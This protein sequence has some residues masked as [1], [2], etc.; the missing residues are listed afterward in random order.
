VRSL[1]GDLTFS[2]LEIEMLE[3]TV[4]QVHKPA[5]T[6]ER[7][8]ET[9]LS[10]N[11]RFNGC[12][13]LDA[14]QF[15]TDNTYFFKLKAFDN[16][17]GK[18]QDGNYYNLDFSFLQ[19]IST[20]D[21]HIRQAVLQLTSDVEHA[22]KIRFNALLM[23][24]TKEDG[25]SIVQDF[26]RHQKQF[27]RDQF[28]K[29]YSLNL[30]AS[31]YTEGIINKYAENPPAWLLWEVCSFNTTNA[32]YKFFLKKHSYQDQIFS[33]L[34]GV[35]LLR[36]AASHNNCLLTA[37]SYKLNQTD[38]RIDLLEQLLPKEKYPTEHDDVM[39][40]AA[41]DPL[42][43]D[44]CCVLCCHIN[45][46]HSQGIISRTEDLLQELIKRIG[47][48]FKWYKDPSNRCKELEE[49]LNAVA[50]VS[51]AFNNF[52]RENC[53]NNNLALT[54]GPKVHSNRRKRRS[55]KSNHANIA[56]L[57]ISKNPTPRSEND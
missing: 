52:S 36:N 17:F 18:D 38:S 1:S 2:V 54:Q 39:R 25:Y 47:R 35:R 28:D 12:T 15:L 37:P 53:C 21:Y 19:D 26:I 11:V 33:L 8:I 20:V 31:V 48:N 57:K 7:Q 27:Y 45:L 43:H 51:H 41:H 50:S 22:I 13:K 34:D 6:P 24:Q 40:L 9:L 56:N 4:E 23:R 44:F 5:A 14:Q 32:F 30:K 49:Q 55:R 42:V 29:Q 10:H 46:V 3:K 16:K